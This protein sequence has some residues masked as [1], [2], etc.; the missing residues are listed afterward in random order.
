MMWYHYLIIAVIVIGLG[1]AA[2]FAGITYRRKVSEREIASA[3]DEAKRIINDAIKTAESKQK[4]ALLEAKDEIHK[5]RT[6]YEKEVR[7]NLHPRRM[8]RVV[9][10]EHCSRK[11]TYTYVCGFKSG[12]KTL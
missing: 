11:D 2:F 10:T 3:E 8:F 9:C 4:E 1:T 7:K 6:E 5:N 12:A